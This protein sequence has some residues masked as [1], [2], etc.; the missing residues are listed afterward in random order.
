MT[1]RRTSLSITKNVIVAAQENEAE[2]NRWSSLVA[3]HPDHVAAQRRA[4]EAFEEI[5]RE[6]N[7]IA[8]AWLRRVVPESIMNG[9]E[10]CPSSCT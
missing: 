5:Q 7:A 8:L 2:F 1:L 9:A 4:L 6:A 10:Y 3:K